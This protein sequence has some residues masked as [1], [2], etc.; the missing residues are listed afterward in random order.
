MPNWT[1]NTITITGEKEELAKMMN[2]AVK[3]EQGELHFSSWFPVPETYNKYDTT[4]HPNGERLVVGEKYWDGLGHK[5]I[6]TEE[7]I[8]ELK[9]A[10][11]EQAE[12]YGAIGW[13][14]YNRKYFGC[15]WDCDVTIE[16][17]GEDEI[18]LKTD[19]PWTAPDKFLIRMSERYP[20]LRFF[21]HAEYEDGDY[22]DCEY[23]EGGL[24]SIVEQG[25]WSEEEE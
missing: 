12:K 10:T 24:E 4:N 20:N 21:N 13:Y 19:T 1:F 15:K 11:A 8:A 23:S 25:R 16:E 22:Q 17:Q 3:D 5:G 2:D 14:D 7:L 6:V 18:L 9:N